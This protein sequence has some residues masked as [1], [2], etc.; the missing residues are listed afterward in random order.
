M[1]KPDKNREETRKKKR[2][3]RNRRDDAAASKRGTKIR[4][5]PL[6]AARAMWG[7]RSTKFPNTEK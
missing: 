3:T 7:E 2:W 1:P 6:N 4:D 5:T